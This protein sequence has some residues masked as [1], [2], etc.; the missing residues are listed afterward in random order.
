MFETGVTDA[1][2][3]EAEVPDH[4]QP[5]K[6]LGTSTAPSKPVL[7]RPWAANVG[8]AV[9]RPEKDQSVIR[10]SWNA[11]PSATTWWTMT[12]PMGKERISPELLSLRPPEEVTFPS[13]ASARQTRPW[14]LQ[15]ASSAPPTPGSED[16][17][18]GREWLFSCRRSLP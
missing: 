16:G 4:G 3:K 14:T 18:P 12:L 7:K 1:G 15:M 10:I 8:D 17:S 2:V 13:W 5:L 6:C 9:I 11:R